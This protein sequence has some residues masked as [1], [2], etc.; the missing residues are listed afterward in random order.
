MRSSTRIRLCWT[1][2]LLAAALALAA[3]GGSTSTG[4][5]TA[6]AAQRASNDARAG[7]AAPATHD[8]ITSGAVTQ[9]PVKGTGG[10][11]IN[12]DNPG[13]AD[14]SGVHAHASTQSNPC[15]LVSKAEAEAIVAAPIADPREAPLGPTCIYQ[16]L[17]AK[18]AVTLAVETVD[19]VKIKPQIHN[20][21]RTAIAG[22]TAY[23]GY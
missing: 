7:A 12:D 16:L 11:A 23:C 14:I 10:N 5:A 19:F 4:S 6:P 21:T 3:C 22:R 2:Q 9:R 18:S 17:D 13:T 20:L 8:V 15:T 1:I